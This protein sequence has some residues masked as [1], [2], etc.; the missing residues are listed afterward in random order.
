MRSVTLY[1]LQTYDGMKWMAPFSKGGGHL[2]NFIS[3]WVK[4]EACWVL[5]DCKNI[6]IQAIF[7]RES[8][9]LGKKA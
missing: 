6:E 3:Q 4:S 9:E 5:D 1:N 7:D 8:F 2:I